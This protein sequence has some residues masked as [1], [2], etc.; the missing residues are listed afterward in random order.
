MFIISKSKKMLQKTFRKTI[1]Q[2]TEIPQPIFK[3]NFGIYVHVP[4]CFSKCSFCPF[5]KEIFTEKLK[6]QYLEA[7]LKEI[8]DT[9]MHRGNAKWLYFG[10]G[11]PNTLTI[12]DLSDIVKQIKRKVKVDSLGIELLPARLD[13]DYL[14]GLKEIGFTKISI[15]VESFSVE[16]AKKAGREISQYEQI[17]R[18]VELSKSLRLWI[19]VDMMVGL[20]DQ[21]S[22]IFRD[23]IRRL[24]TI[25]PDQITT[26]PF[27][28]IDGVKSTPS[29][30]PIEQFKLIEETNE[31]L[32]KYGYSRSNIWAF[33]L[34][35]ELYDSSGDEL[36]E[37]YIGFGP[38]AFST[39]G[40]WEIMNPDLYTYIN[41]FKN[42][43]KMGFISLRTKA[44][45]EWRKFAKMIYD[46]KCDSDYYSNFALYIKLFIWILKL[47]KYSEKGVL[48]EKGK[49]FAHE[50]TKT[51]VE[52]IPSPIRNKHCVENY[53]EYI[54]YKNGDSNK[55][56]Y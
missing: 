6:K 32:K 37:D 20:P 38:A 13:D 40:D 35:D 47:A 50:I 39:Y 53:N 52:T 26:Y 23:D 17:K 42:D 27:M 16:V 19:S 36:V 1:Y 34:D 28:V 45:D 46:I 4:F 55:N 31:I 5:Y 24:I 51:V 18:I 9:D 10:G 15:G 54:S 2:F 56:K 22:N 21:D 44:S 12:K 41:N 11:T 30:S 8:D 29:I 3:G 43:K 7:L 33:C 48:T 49:I 25:H 14:K